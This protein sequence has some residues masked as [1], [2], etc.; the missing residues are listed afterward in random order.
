MCLVHRKMLTYIEKMAWTTVSLSSPS[1]CS[2]QSFAEFSV[3]FTHSAV[4]F[5]PSGMK[6]SR[7]TL[8]FASIPQ[9][10]YFT[11]QPGEFKVMIGV[12]I[13]HNT[14]PERLNWIEALKRA[15]SEEMEKTVVILI[16]DGFDVLH[17]NDSLWTY[18][19]HHNY[20]SDQFPLIEALCTK[21]NN[22]EKK[23]TRRNR[24]I[25]T[26]SLLYFPKNSEDVQVWVLVKPRPQGRLHSDLWFFAG[27]AMYYE[28]GILGLV[29]SELCPEEGGVECMVRRLGEREGQL[30]GIIG[31]P[32]IV[33]NDA[34][35]AVIIQE[36][37]I[38]SEETERRTRNQLPELL[39]EGKREGKKERWMVRGLMY[40][41]RRAD[42]FEILYAQIM[43]GPIENLG[44]YVSQPLVRYAFYNWQVLSESCSSAL[45]DYFKPFTSGHS[46]SWLD[47]NLYEYVPGLFLHLKARMQPGQEVRFEFNWEQP[48]PWYLPTPLVRWIQYRARVANA[49]LLSYLAI[50]QR[51]PRCAV[52]CG[53]FCEL[54]WVF[55]E[56]YYFHIA[57]LFKWF[58]IGAYYV[59][60]SIAVRKFL[61]SGSDVDW[62]YISWKY[63]YLL[64]LAVVFFMSLGKQRDRGKYIWYLI[65]LLN[66]GQSLF[67]FAAI[68]Y[69]VFMS[70]RDKDEE[71]NTL[72]WVGIGVILLVAMSFP[73]GYVMWM[74]CGRKRW[75]CR[76]LHYIL[77][78][79]IYL[80]LFPVYTNLIG[81]CAVCNTS[82]ECWGLSITTSSTRRAAVQSV[83]SVHKN[84]FLVLFIVLNLL[85]GVTW[86][87]QDA[88]ESKDTEVRKVFLYMYYGC[89][90]VLVLPVCILQA[91]FR[92]L[93]YWKM[94]PRDDRLQVKDRASYPTSSPFTIT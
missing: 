80:V 33:V 31:A 40:L 18:F 81:I 60:S 20:C 32:E 34:K 74:G 39:K 22:R 47:N 24:A 58:S 52:C 55:I 90:F 37:H 11:Q 83:L 61:E 28:P 6:N 38:N 10:G 67:N 36:N 16:I 79:I 82:E 59:L 91:L 13:D 69:N 70:N 9:E 63:G 17:R 35:P 62:I 4:N 12:H 72:V 94:R 68:I 45:M 19:L 7:E 26:S 51:T 92:V 21:L 56:F 8:H 14:V 84:L 25:P 85:F 50:I 71:V 48:A 89:V 2:P 15:K 49:S 30:G 5:N 29:D 66:I 42:W 53:S 64:V 87:Y 88:E 1:R 44:G 75:V 65:I 46:L 86:E 43:Y 77:C 78:A 23:N 76:F 73:I 41:L 3:D 57:F 27:F 54:A 93:G